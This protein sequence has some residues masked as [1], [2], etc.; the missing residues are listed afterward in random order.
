MQG[1]MDQDVSRID[2]SNQNQAF[3][4]KNIAQGSFGTLDARSVECLFV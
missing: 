4:T 3:K 1:L 2:K